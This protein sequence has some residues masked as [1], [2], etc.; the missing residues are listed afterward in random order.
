M[1]GEN[2][3][4]HLPHTIF[5]CHIKRIRICKLHSFVNH[6]NNHRYTQH[7]LNFPSTK[8]FAN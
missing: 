3:F 8:Q 4:E 6:G 5:T 2:I 1:I 7:S